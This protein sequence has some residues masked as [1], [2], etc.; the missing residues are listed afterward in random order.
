VSSSYE[1][2]MYKLMNQSLPS[3][4]GIFGATVI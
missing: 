2:G 4:A 1:L 3:L